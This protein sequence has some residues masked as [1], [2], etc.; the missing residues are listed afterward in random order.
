MITCDRASRKK[1][2]R[3]RQALSGHGPTENEFFNTFYLFVN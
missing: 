2:D 1:I 3:Y